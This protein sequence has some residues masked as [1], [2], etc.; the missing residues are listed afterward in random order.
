M[1]TTRNHLVADLLRLGL[2]SND[3][4]MLHASVR[5]V[6]GV[7]GGPD[8]IHQ[9]AGQVIQPGGTL[10]MYVGCQDGFDEVGRGFL[11]A[12]EEA[13]VLEHQPFFS[14]AY[15]RSARDFGTLA[16]FFRS[17]PGTVCSEHVGAR[18][19]ARGH[20]ADWFTADHPW[21]YGYGIGSPLHKL[22]Q[23]GGKVLLLGSRHD[24]VT[25]L[26]YAEHIAAFDGKRI[27]RYK[28][29]LERDGERV[30]V[31]CE[32]FNTSAEGVHPAWPANF[33]EIIVD[34]FIAK[35][36]GSVLCR[37]G[38]VGSAESVLMDARAL[39]EHA[40]PLMVARAKGR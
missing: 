12:E 19:A 32:E 16:E 25:L 10:L 4:V 23:D 37:R 11:S 26:H 21:N 40:L 27:V 22:C 14:F 39:V 36:G 13:Q 7:H 38:P 8:E 34:D 35:H 18:I 20:R 24:E 6:G 30:W 5:A 33:F 9:A 3:D 1:L 31:D 2:K 15:A 28:V 17:S 29:P